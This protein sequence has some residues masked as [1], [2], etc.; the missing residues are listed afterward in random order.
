MD[1]KN[2]YRI[3][4][5]NKLKAIIILSIVANALYRFFSGS[6]LLK[7]IPA[8][9]IIISVFHLLKS[10]FYLKK[11][12]KL[13]SYF[14]IVL[15]LLI[16]WC[17]ITII[18]GFTFDISN[19]IVLFTNTK[20]G[21]PVWLTPLLV[22][23]AINKNIWV[24]IFPFLFKLM[25]LG[26]CFFILELAFG[27][28]LDSLS[29]LS[30]STF[31]VLSRSLHSKRVNIISSITFLL[32]FING[33]LIL[34]H[35]AYILVIFLTIIFTLFINLKGKLRYIFISILSVFLTI[36]FYLNIMTQIEKNSQFVVDTRSFLIEELF[37]DMTPS[38]LM[39]GRGALG[40]YYSNYFDTLSRLGTENIDN[41][42]RSLNEIG[43]LHYILKGGYVM[44]I[45]NL[46]ILIPAAY[47][48]IF[49]SKNTI[50]KMSGYY[51]LHFIILSTVI[52]PSEYNIEFALLW[53][54][55]GTNISQFIRKHNN[56]TIKRLING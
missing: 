41:E 24:H 14:K 18:R 48:G 28:Y 12:I 9:L 38:E 55:V 54:A 53:L 50:C 35:R 42:N 8:I 52:Y 25:I 3:N 7:S 10:S 23:F 1:F 30:I 33:V 20:V 2:N 5:L 21:G 39:I 43:Y 32:L 27:F 17:F 45:L 31:F 26:C 6:F 16:I 49:K 34:D 40:K 22:F 19:L 15:S 44:L 36:T 37:I 47:L 13:P 46:L 29:L 51:I 56:Y 4:Y 11:K